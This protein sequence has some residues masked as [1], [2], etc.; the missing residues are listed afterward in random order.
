MKRINSTV[1]KKLVGSFLLTILFS[2]KINF[3]KWRR[4]KTALENVGTS[5]SCTNPGL[6]RRKFLFFWRF[7]WISTFIQFSFLEIF[8]H[9]VTVDGVEQV[10]GGQQLL[11]D[12]FRL[13]RH[14]GLQLAVGQVWKKGIRG[15]SSQGAVH[16]LSNANLK[17]FLNPPPSMTHTFSSK[18]RRYIANYSFLQISIETFNIFIVPK[19]R[20]LI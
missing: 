16:K 19:W 4:L 1:E 10:L 11:V 20:H 8:Q 7:Q 2:V 15:W 3:K 18:G 17:F 5:F 12:L 9:F 6:I 14:V 13:V